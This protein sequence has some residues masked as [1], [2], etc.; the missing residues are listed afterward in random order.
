MNL[1][2]RAHAVTPWGTQT[3]AKRIPT[4][5]AGIMPAFITHA[6]GCRMTADDGRTFIDYRSA[7]GPI[8]L[9]YTH[10]DVDDAVR[11]KLFKALAKET[12][13][14]SLN[15][16]VTRLESLAKLNEN[17]RED[18]IES[19]KM[20]AKEMTL[21]VWTPYADRLIKACE[22]EMRVTLNYLLYCE[23]L[24]Y[25]KPS[26][27]NIKKLKQSI[28]ENYDFISMINNITKEVEDAEKKISDETTESAKTDEGERPKEPSDSQT[29]SSI[30]EAAQA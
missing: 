2:E 28:S 23:R 19:L 11:D 26:D 3:N 29:I 12:M 1:L 6:H 30:P 17:V 16:E 14:N 7:L 18:E 27:E 22:K 13:T 21:K 20:L 5:L 9:G 25:A 4:A 15:A 24:E 8:I 10:P